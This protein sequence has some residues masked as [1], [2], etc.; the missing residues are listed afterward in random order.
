MLDRSNTSVLVDKAANGDDGAFTKLVQAW[1]KRIYNFN[2]KYFFDHDLAMEMTQKTFISAHRN[3]GKL[4]NKERFSGWLYTIAVNYCRE[5]DRRQGKKRIIPILS[6]SGRETCYESIDLQSHHKNTY[7]PEKS[8]QKDELS[9]I[10]MKALAKI[11]AEQK[12]VLIMKE[13]EG[14]KFKEIAE[15]LEISENTAKSRL[16]YGLKALKKI[17]DEWK[18]NKEEINYGS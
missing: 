15:S 18:I 1:Y 10:L 13:Y 14:L 2:Y 8:F 9:G 17:L 12:V 3:I 5:E 6:M 16:Y 11:P 7:D 4:K